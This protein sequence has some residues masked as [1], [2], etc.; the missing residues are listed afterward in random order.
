MPPIYVPM[1]KGKE[2]EFAAL[3]TLTP[4]VRGQIMPLIEV[5]A[6][7]FDYANARPAK[8]LAA[9]V[10]GIAER[11]RRSMN[12]A[13]VFLDLPWFDE[14]EDIED[15]RIALEAVLTDC[16]RLG[17]NAVPV[18]STSSS[19]NYLAAADR[20]SATNRTGTCIR[21]SVSDFGEDTDIDADV[22]G[23][24][25][26]LQSVGVNNI[27]LIVDLRDLDSDPSRAVLIARSVFSMIPRKQ[28]WRRIILAAAS[29]PEDLSDVDAASVAKVPRREWELWKTLQKKPAIL[30]RR[31]MIFADYAISHSIP[32][33]LDPRTMRMSANVRY[34]TLDHWL[35]LKG[36]NVR[37][38]GFEQY[39]DL[40]R[41][42]VERL[43]YSGADYSWGD[44]YIADCAARR[45]GPGNAT[46]WRKVG[47][48]HHVTLLTREIANLNRAV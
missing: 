3:E 30:P 18:V 28:E 21:L 31:E 25:N 20:H 13:P 11:I 8:T 35:I 42:L 46:T 45:V 43:E 44:S 12:Q 32:K 4:D 33:E 14:A 27:D 41:L 47:T 26:S 2:G 1:L 5:P 7:P 16:A 40:C 24:L 17:V 22:D 29:F 39:F 36:R 10:A 38:Y 23:M 15:G 48:N 34:T 19:P 6:V 37:Q 9:H